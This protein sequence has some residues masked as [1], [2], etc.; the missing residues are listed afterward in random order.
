MRR[1][2]L[3]RSLAVLGAALPLRA[4]LGATPPSSDLE[5]LDV[6]L[7]GDAKLARRALVLVPRHAGSDGPMPVLVLLHGLGETGDEELGIH[8]WGERY[9][10]VRAYERLRRP[11]VER[12][13]PKVRYL[14]DER[15]ARINEGL[16]RR[17]FPPLVL[18]CP[19]TPNPGRH[20]SPA[21]A[22]DAYAAW[23]GETLLPEV[24]RRV[25]RADVSR[26][27]LDGCSLGGYVALE[28]FAR[29]A[30]RFAT[31]GTVQAAFGVHRARGYAE[32][33]AGAM[34]GKRKTPVHVLTSSEDPY[35][36]ANERFGRELERLGVSSE[37]DVLPGPHNQPWLREAGTLE[38][39]RWHARELVGVEASR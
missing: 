24:G 20:A 35:R 9:G 21:R 38:M 33:V 37:L 25:A 2:E 36:K 31:L 26:V 18:V 7:P 23:L 16:A 30:A 14:T 10:L 8:A 27:G 22:L 12:T 13:E 5:A 3:L 32:R 4:V 15:L 1:R 28:V 19:V 6:R 29:D 17:P 34:A 39:L 11:P